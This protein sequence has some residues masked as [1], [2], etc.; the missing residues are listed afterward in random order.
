MRKESGFTLIELIV[1]I[2]ILGILA[3][4]ALP[5]M[6][7]LSGDARMAVM[8]GAEGS[9]RAANALIYARASSLGIQSQA[10][11]TIAANTMGNTG[12][13]TLAYGF[14]ATVTDLSQIMDLQPA[15]DFTIAATTLSHARANTPAT[16]RITYVAAANQNT[17]PTYTE[18]P[19][20][21]TTAGC[22]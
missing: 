9:M 3:A 13:I 16:C 12:A 14:A 1:V 6:V 5:K 2:V 21:L 7:N 20:P 22:S 4:T 8:K 19:N 11:G 18:T 15:A 17:P 10:A